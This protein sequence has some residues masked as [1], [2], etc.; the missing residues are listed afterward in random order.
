MKLSI[1][2]IAWEKKH[3]ILIFNYLKKK[4]FKSIEVAPCRIF[5]NS[6]YSK[7]SQI[8]KYSIFLKKKYNLEICSVQSIWTGR[9]EKLFKSNSERK[10]L[11]NYSKKAIDFASHA[12]AHNIVLGSP[13]NRYMY[14]KSQ[15][16]MA[17][18]FFNS[19]GEYALK[20]NIFF[21]IEPNP[22]I[23]NTNFINT[24]HEAFEFVKKVNSKG[25]KVNVDTGTMICNN[26]DIDVLNNNFFLINHVHIS[27]PYLKL[28]KKRKFHKKLSDFLKKKKY[29]KFVSVEMKN[30]NSINS[31]YKTID[32]V[33]EVFD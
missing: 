5:E 10:F 8:S 9:K 24:T 17:S 1:S 11:L 30:F 2:N 3:D 27:E 29:N 31:V 25:I 21:S 15:F 18:D 14:D 4:K 26:E 33:K 32:Y 6:P 12:G 28:I 7:L 19:L 13:A 20:R 23:Y 22:V 16:E